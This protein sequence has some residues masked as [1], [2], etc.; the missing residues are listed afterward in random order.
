[1]RTITVPT[2][3]QLDEKGLQI[4]D[5]VKGQLGMIPNLYATIAYS[6]DALE[7]FLN[8]SSLAGKGSFS[9][10][11]L[12]AIRLAV[13][14]VNECQYCLA[15]HTAIAKMN[16]LS[17]EETL[18]IRDGSIK[19]SKL[20]ALSNLA[21]EISRK[22]G[23]ASNEAKE[24]FFAAGFNEKALIDILAV[25]TEITFTNYTHNLT[26]VPVD[27]PKAKALVKKAA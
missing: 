13:S 9:G 23:K 10:K 27:F 4:L 15:A 17:E 19:D 1:M 16:G 5:K 22:N 14:E 12:E 18:Q 26:E 24:N 8:F 20:S 7:N 3:E 6:S 25:V 21:A 2:R 11:E